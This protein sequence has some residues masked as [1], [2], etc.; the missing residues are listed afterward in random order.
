MYA[1]RSAVITLL[2]SLLIVL[3]SSLPANA[4]P[5]IA[6]DSEAVDYGSVP[7]DHM[8]TH[9]FRFINEGDEPLRITGPFCHEGLIMARVLDGC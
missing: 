5:R 7:F 4:A 3:M 8:V 1:R 6:F 2:V 9:E